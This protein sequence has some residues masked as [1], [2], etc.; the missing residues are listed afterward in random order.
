M[1]ASL[2]A[3]VVDCRD[4][5]RQARFWAQALAYE[6]NQRNPGEF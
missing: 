2:L 4:P 1:S 6:V 3:I 5:L